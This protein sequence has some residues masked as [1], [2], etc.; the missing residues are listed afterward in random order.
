MFGHN[1][2]YIWYHVQLSAC[3]QTIIPCLAFL[4]FMSPYIDGGVAPQAC[5]W[6]V[7]WPV[8]LIEA[9][10]CNYA[11][12]KLTIIGSENDL[13][14]GRCQA[15]I[16]AN[17]G[18]LVIRPRGKNFNEISIEIHASSLKKIQLKMSFGKWWPFCLG[19]S[20][21]YWAAAQ[22]LGQN[23]TGSPGPHSDPIQT[24]LPDI[25]GAVITGSIFPQIF[26]K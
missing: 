17:A 19:H 16:W 4:L 13:S 20:V 5:L 10:W 24:V 14:P 23:H 6:F 22:S 8:Y 9:E 7:L 3:S 15:I 2:S 1:H 26:T 11:S 12:G 21:L 25:M 18:T